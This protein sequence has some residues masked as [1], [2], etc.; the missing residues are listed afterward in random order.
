MTLAPFHVCVHTGKETPVIV[1]IPHAGLLVPPHVSPELLAS[2]RAMGRDADLYVDELYTEAHALGASVL[3][4]RNS[5]YVVDLNRAESDFDAQSVA[6]GPDGHSPR[7]VI[8]R[9]TSEGDRALAA[10]LRRDAFEWRLK[11]I[12]RPYHAK[13][14]ELIGEKK[15]R[16]GLAIVLA[17]HSMPSE[18]STLQSDRPARGGP[19]PG[20]SATRRSR[21]ADVVPG[22]LG[23]TSAHGRFIDLV[24][25]HARQAGLSV[26]HDDPYRGGFT[27]QHY[28]RPDANVHVV[29]VE[30]ARR[31]YMDELSLRQRPE[32]F[33]QLRTW[34]GEL[35]AKLG[36]AALT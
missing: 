7:G 9:V 25:A 31:L 12:Y 29:Q 34:C 23:R 11:E 22:T 14:A 5:R 32:P 1:E 24:D 2:A 28:G 20:G 30:L 3:R 18:G 16:F 8:W 17:A 19:Q 15:E 10:P 4:A 33:E 21:R 27:T 36:H 35:V 6:G 13:L 26:M